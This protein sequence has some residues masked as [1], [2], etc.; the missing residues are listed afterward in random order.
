MIIDPSKPITGRI[1]LPDIVESCTLVPVVVYYHGGGSTIYGLATIISLEIY[2][3]S[4]NPLAPE[5]RLP[6]AYD[7]CYNSLEW[8]CTQVTKEPWFKLADL[9]RVFLSGD[10]AGGNIVH[11][12]AI[13]A[14]RNNGGLQV[15]IKGVLLI[16][17]YFGSEERTE[18]E[19]GMVRQAMWQ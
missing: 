19:R 10:S 8:L 16:H 17:P 18:E 15:K 3:L 14:I 7:D 13:K 12:V 9:S 11:Q 6:T 2:L 1:F 4:H 5:H